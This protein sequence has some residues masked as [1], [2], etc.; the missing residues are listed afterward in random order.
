VWEFVK[1]EAASINF[2]GRVKVCDG[3]KFFMGN[4]H[5]RHS[6]GVLQLQQLPFKWGAFHDRKVFLQGMIHNYG[7]LSAAAGRCAAASMN[8]S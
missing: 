6:G 1:A 7:T 3:G 4:K 2:M 8:F 5:M